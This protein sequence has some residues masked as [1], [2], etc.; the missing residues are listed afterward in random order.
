MEN[1]GKTNGGIGKIRKVI[2]KY[3]TLF[4]HTYLVNWQK[5]LKSYFSLNRLVNKSSNVSMNE[6]LKRRLQVFIRL[7]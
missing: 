4:K 5:S 7:N 6:N 3:D 1:D 2:I